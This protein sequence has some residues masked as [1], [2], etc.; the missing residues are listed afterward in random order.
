MHIVRV[1]ESSFDRD[2]YDFK[3]SVNVPDE[4]APTPHNMQVSPENTPKV[5]INSPEYGLP[6]IKPIW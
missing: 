2:D 5:V 1:P 3:N 6:T 4:Y